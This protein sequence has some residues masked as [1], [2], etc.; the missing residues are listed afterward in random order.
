M[1]LSRL[2][3][4]GDMD[5][6]SDDC[7]L[8]A[9]RSTDVLDAAILRKTLAEALEDK[10][11][12]IGTT[13][14][15]R[16]RRRTSSPQESRKEILEIAAKQEVA[17]LFGREDHGLFKEELALCHRVL[18]IPTSS[19]RASINIAQAVLIVAYELFQGSTLNAK[20]ASTDE[21]N[22]L[23]GGQWQ[24]LYDEM[25]QSCIDV[26]YLD[27]GNRLAIEE[28]L[29]RFLKLG[30]IQTRDARHLFGL[31]RRVAKILDGKEKPNRGFLRDPQAE[32]PGRE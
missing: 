5:L 11:F 7:R 27:E 19:E 24:R 15:E 1:G 29:R 23:A 9:S 26:A 2:E 18:S 12:V 16:H 3:I 32:E 31:L 13:A 14:R 21:G 10:H 20:T 28:S 30:P 4:V 8:L 17:I 25:L 22:L 6:Q